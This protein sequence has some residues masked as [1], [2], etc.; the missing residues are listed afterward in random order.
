M[1]K[2]AVSTQSTEAIFKSQN[3]IRWPNMVYNALIVTSNLR[4]VRE[5]LRDVENIQ[6]N[7]V[8]LSG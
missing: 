6:T 7:R 3:K 2:D 5:Q 1:K 8:C 4:Y